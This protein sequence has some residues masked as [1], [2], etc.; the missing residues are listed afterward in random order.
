[1]EQAP[2]LFAHYFNHSHTCGYSVLALQ[3]DHCGTA[4][5][6]CGCTACLCS[7]TRDRSFASLHAS[8][9]CYGAGVPG[10]YR[11]VRVSRLYHGQDPDSP[12]E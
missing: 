9:P 5:L 6:A 4:H 2:G 7:R 3:P 1:M 10:R 11:S 12:T 8:F